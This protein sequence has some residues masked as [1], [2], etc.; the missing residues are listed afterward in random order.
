M[1]ETKQQWGL[2]LGHSAAMQLVVSTAKAA[3][4]YYAYKYC[5]LPMCIPATEKPAIAQSQKSYFMV[6]GLVAGHEILYLLILKSAF[7]AAEYCTPEGHQLILE[8]TSKAETRNGGRKEEIGLG[9]S[10]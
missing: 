2:F 5:R 10:V 6:P 7:R 4:V 1:R 9:Y 8:M 3:A